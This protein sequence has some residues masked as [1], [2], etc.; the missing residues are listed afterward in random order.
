MALKHKIF[1]TKNEEKTY[2]ELKCKT[3]CTLNASID[4]R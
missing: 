1:E 2:M 3:P 4:F